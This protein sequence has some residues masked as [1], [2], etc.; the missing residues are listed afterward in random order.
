MSK[1][2]KVESFSYVKGWGFITP[3]DGGPRAFVHFS[4]IDPKGHRSIRDGAS[5]E[6]EVT[7]GP[8]GR[9]AVNVRPTNR[10]SL[11]GSC[12]SCTE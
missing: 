11:R 7:E 2:G 3:D 1:T 6:F 5:V 8:R 10:S 9:L 12:P 4:N